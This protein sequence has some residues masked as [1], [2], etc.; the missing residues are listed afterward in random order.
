M[1][2][3]SALIA[4]RLERDTHVVRIKKLMLYACNDGWE[5]DSARLSAADLT[6]LIDELHQRYPTVEHL[7]SR[8]NHL[9]GTL[10]KSIEYQSVA[11]LITVALSA[12][13]SA[14]ISNP[15]ST[16]IRSLPQL[17]PTT[18]Q[19]NV[20]EILEQ[21][22]NLSRIKKLLICVC[23]KYWEA[24]P[25]VIEQ[26]PLADLL[27][28]LTKRY[29]KLGS[30]RD[31]LAAAVKTL[32]KPIEYALVA[33]AI[34][35]VIEPLYETEAASG[36]Q[37]QST[38]M[39]GFLQTTAQAPTPFKPMPVN[40][41]DV[42]LEIFKHTNPLRAKILLFSLA[43]YPFE[44]R[45]HDWANLKLYSLEGL[46]R[47]V[48]SQAI[49]TGYPS[50]AMALEE[51]RHKLQT[52]A[53]QFSDP[54]ELGGIDRNDYLTVGQALMKALTPNYAAL[55]HQIQQASQS[56]SAA[57][58]TCASSTEMVIK[59]PLVSSELLQSSDRQ[60]ISG[61]AAV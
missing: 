33:E 1:S 48:L 52:M 15:E 37:A 31:G 35:Q 12:L 24:N 38:V 4:D 13:Y 34:L 47:T 61:K 6:E 32:N 5:S 46:L 16:Q 41:F 20:A 8:L 23:R 42:R 49:A 26:T 17:R 14:G 57:D 44:F 58:I 11:H 51:L 29:S 55:Q 45:S 7:R 18:P 39:D 19:A 60:D 21:D 10:N 36:Q 27:H 3:A 28:E 56:G 54:A 40:L 22:A 50:P 25:Y 9:V 53:Q 59:P 43:Y 30:L 2:D